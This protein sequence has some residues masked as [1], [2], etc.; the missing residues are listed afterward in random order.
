MSS[1][2]QRGLAGRAHVFVFIAVTLTSVT[3]APSRAQAPADTKDTITSW[4]QLAKD[5]FLVAK[6]DKGT[7]SLSVYLLG[8]YI[9]QLPVGQEFTDHLGGVHSV[10]TRNDV[11]LHRMQF[12]ARGW[13]YEPSFGYEFQAWASRSCRPARRSRQQRPRTEGN[14]RHLVRPRWQP[15]RFASARTGEAVTA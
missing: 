5:G 14:R 15:A 7:R 2:P 3:R 4:G 10:D 11:A 13:F 1:H 12:F 9:N 8:R 6:T